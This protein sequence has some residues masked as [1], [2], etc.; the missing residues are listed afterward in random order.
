MLTSEEPSSV[1]DGA[2]LRAGGT[3][4]VDGCELRTGRGVVEEAITVMVVLEADGLFSMDPAMDEY[5]L[6]LMLRKLKDGC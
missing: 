5:K 4:M 3:V 6:L 2:E 1:V